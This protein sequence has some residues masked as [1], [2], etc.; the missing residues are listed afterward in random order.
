[1]NFLKRLTSV[2]KIMYLDETWI[3]T[4]IAKNKA[5]IGPDFTSKFK[6]VGGKRFTITH[7]E[8]STGFVPNALK[9]FSPTQTDGDYH[10]CMDGI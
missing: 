9:L 6:K 5:W 3:D 8:S 2:S 10:K 1:M 7:A 4:R